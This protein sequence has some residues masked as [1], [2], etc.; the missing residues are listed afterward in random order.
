MR[1]KVPPVTLLQYEVKT[2]SWPGTPCV[3]YNPAPRVYLPMIKRPINGSDVLTMHPDVPVCP[4]LEAAQAYHNEQIKAAQEA[5]QQAEAPA[6][7]VPPGRGRL[8]A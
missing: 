3:V 1:K 7:Y 6:L 8:Q 4:T 2:Y 5:R